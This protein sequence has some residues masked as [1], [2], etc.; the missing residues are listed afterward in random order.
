MATGAAVAA[1]PVKDT[2]K[3][4]SGQGLVQSTPDR[5]TLW[6][7]QTPQV[8]KYDLL[9]RAHRECSEAVTDDAAMVERLGCP[10]RVFEGSYSNI[11]V[12]T[13]DDLV[14]A[15][16]ILRARRAGR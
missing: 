2:I 7:V 1:V 6:A 9:C 16:A 10:V 5:G 3:V 11:K 15:E 4:V 13:P 8:F 14:L 12:T